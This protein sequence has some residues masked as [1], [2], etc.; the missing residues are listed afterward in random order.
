MATTTHDPVCGMLVDPA[1]ATAVEYEGTVYYFCE[2]ACADTFG[3]DPVRW[4]PEADGLE[5]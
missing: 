3:D 2:P 5:A 4:I 1:V